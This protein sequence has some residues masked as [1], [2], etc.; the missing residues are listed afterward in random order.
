MII[1]SANSHI[2]SIQEDDL[3]QVYEL[4]QQLS[5]FK[6]KI[7]KYSEIFDLFLSQDVNGLVY[8]LENKII[9]VAFI[10][11]IRKIRGG[12]VGQIEDVA[13]SPQYQG[14]GF[15]SKLIR[16]LIRIANKKKCYVVS[17][18]TSEKNISF[19]EKLSFNKAEIEM[20]QK[21]VTN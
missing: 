15:G 21:L 4:L 1:K 17:L 9:G 7:S 14:Y 18:V 10:Y 5:D 8:V 2:R 6:P 12:L 16:E 11:F 13:V 20:R 19:Y 3:E